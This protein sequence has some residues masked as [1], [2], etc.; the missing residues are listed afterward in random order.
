MKPPSTTDALSDVRA[1]IGQAGL[2]RTAARIAVLRQ[3]REARVPLSHAD[4][5]QRLSEQGFDKATV[6]RNLVELAEAGIV[7]RFELGD[8]VWRFE[9]RDQSS[10]RYTEHPHFLCLD[11]GEISCLTD[12]TVS[13]SPSPGSKRSRVAD[14]SEVLL[15]GRCDRCG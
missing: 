4:V 8:H 2:R 9:W 3:L 5:S 7:S 15:K 1:R 12:V 6:Y 13:I 11:C 10:D 14:V